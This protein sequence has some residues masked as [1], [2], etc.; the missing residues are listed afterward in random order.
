MLPLRNELVEFIALV[1]G[2][3]PAADATEHIAETLERVLR[4][5]YPPLI[6]WA[7]RRARSTV[8]RFW[9]MSCSSTP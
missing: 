3:L 2:S 4:F 1:I 8:L 7:S 6:E 9:A 5:R